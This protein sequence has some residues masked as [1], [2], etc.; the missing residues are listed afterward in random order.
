[1]QALQQQQQHQQQQQQQAQAAASIPMYQPPP[2]ALQQQPNELDITELETL[3]HKI[4]ESCT[5]DSIS[6]S[7]SASCYNLVSLKCGLN[8]Y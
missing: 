1:M 7:H 5:K 4:M 2:V 3:L 6:V 8:V